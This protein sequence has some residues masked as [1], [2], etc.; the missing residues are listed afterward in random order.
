MNNL[1][2]IIKS[3]MNNMPEGLLRDITDEFG[4]AVGNIAGEILGE[5]S[6]DRTKERI[7]QKLG[8]EKIEEM[9]KEKQGQD[10][11]K[12]LVQQ[13]DMQNSSKISKPSV[14][15]KDIFSEEEMSV[16]DLRRAI[17]WSEILGKPACKK[18]RNAGRRK[19]C[20]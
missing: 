14:S 16:E 2:S 9:R 18:R 20:Q 4:S 8:E 17:I 12:A 7:K 5:F 3:A 1:N 13:T 10:K 19:E 15:K 6:A 11:E